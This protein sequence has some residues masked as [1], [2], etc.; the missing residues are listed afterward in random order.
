[1]HKPIGKQMLSRNLEPQ[2]T[3]PIIESS[4]SNENDVIVHTDMRLDNSKLALNTFG[5][6]PTVPLQVY[7]GEVVHCQHTPSSLEARHIIRAT[8]MP[9]YMQCHIPVQ[10]GINIKAWRAHLSNYWDQQLCDLL[11]FG[12]PFDFYRN[13]V[14]NFLCDQTCEIL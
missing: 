11:E 5:F 14:L 13:C 8:K 1:M 10:S 4:L 7:T 12:F 9:N 3:Y 6:I 2:Y